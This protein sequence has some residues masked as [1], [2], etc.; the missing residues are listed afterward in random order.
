M[1]GFNSDNPDIVCLHSLQND[2]ATRASTAV[3]KDIKWTSFDSAKQLVK[4]GAA[5]STDFWV[6]CGY[7]GWG[8]GQ[9]MGELERKSW[10]MV[11]TDSQTLLKE[12]AR[13]GSG[14]DP[15][16]AGLE[17]WTLLMNMIGRNETAKEH[18]GDFDDLMLK[19][20]ALEN[21]LSKAAGGGA[22]LSMG[23]SSV[24][25]FL[26][27]KRLLDASLGRK[28]KAGTLLR[29]A[30]NQRSPFLLEDQELHKSIVLIIV[31]ESS[32]CIGVILSRPAAKGLDIQI[33]EKNS[34]I[35][36]K[37]QV[38]LRYGGQYAV[39]GSD[40]LLWLH[41]HSTLKSAEIGS[42]IGQ[43]EGIWKCSSNDV[44]TAVGQGLA[45]PEEFMV[46]SGV[47]VWG[48]EQGNRDDPVVKPEKF[49]VIPDWKIPSIW[50]ELS[51]Q[52]VLS[53]TNLESNLRIADRAW[54]K[55]G[56]SGVGGG[57]DKFFSVPIG[58]IGEGFDEDDDSLVFKSNVKVSKL[59]DDAL[60][61]WVAT[62][63][64]GTPTLK[65]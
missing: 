2:Q 65:K 21:L 12:L 20:W 56:E 32:L 23:K 8:P 30:P 10:Y 48:K 29:A 53:P 49:E 3:M 61:S 59:C 57:K 25:G 60:R 58:G 14:A 64:L 24:V 34:R 40:P 43:R 6:F 36:R 31:D 13:Q 41:C 22:E 52:E 37:I 9:L 18:T 55:G 47:L 28:L 50:E 19:E 4:I 27:Q 45:V 26:T 62:F 35:S 39:K 16:D 44:I 11:A 51:N 38:P 42:P 54:V 63:L 7:A 17:A 15:R 5:K 33:T 46:V 1:Q